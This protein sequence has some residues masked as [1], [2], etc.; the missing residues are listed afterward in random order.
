MGTVQNVGLMAK[1]AE[2]YGSHDKTF[3]IKK[4]GQIK[5]QTKDGITLGRFFSYPSAELLVSISYGKE[6][7]NSKI[8]KERN[9]NL[10]TALNL[11]LHKMGVSLQTGLISEKNGNHGIIFSGEFS[12][13]IVSNTRFLGLNLLKEIGY[14][15]FYASSYVGYSDNEYNKRSYISSISDVLIA[16]SKI[17]FLPKRAVRS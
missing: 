10:I 5:V 8:F 15:S 14:A 12:D 1:K 11:N 6:S 9:S 3:E 2:E 17:E 13:G 4:S 7:I 16:I